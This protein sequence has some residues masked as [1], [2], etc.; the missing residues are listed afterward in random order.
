[1]TERVRWTTSRVIG[2]PDPA[3]PYELRRVFSRFTFENPVFI[4]QDPLS[5]R[6]LVAEY[7]GRI[8][9][10]FGSDSEGTKD[11]FLDTKRRISAFSFH[12][13]YRDNGRVSVFSPTDPTLEDKEDKGVEQ[14]SRVSQFERERGSDPPRLRPESETIIIEWPRVATTAA[15]Q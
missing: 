4:A 14:I 10:F 15:K 5:D 13:Q 3:T 7:G 8:Y 12:P 9:S 11:L 1:M 2:S 6:L